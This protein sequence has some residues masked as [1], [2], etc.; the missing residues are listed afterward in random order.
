L[1]ARP[2]WSGKRFRRSSLEEGQNRKIFVSLIEKNFGG[3]QLKNVK[4]IFL[5]CS[6]SG[7]RKR[8]AGFLPIRAEIVAQ[9]RFALRSVIATNLNIANFGG[10]LFARSPRLRRGFARIFPYISAQNQR[11]FENQKSVFCPAGGGSA[12]RSNAIPQ[13]GISNFFLSAFG[14]I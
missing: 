4:K 7:E 10:S 9:K 14:G 6:L 13:N 8:W 2:V 5:F 12:L 11:A 1:P 3:A